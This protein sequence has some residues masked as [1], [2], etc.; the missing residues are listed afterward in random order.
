MAVGILPPATSSAANHKSLAEV[1]REVTA[2]NARVDAAVEAYNQSRI[3]LSA[4]ARRTAAAQHRL[5]LQA[6]VIDAQ[7]K[8]ISQVAVAAYRTGGADQFVSLVTTNNPESFLDRAASLNQISSHQSDALRNLQVAQLAYA[9]AQAVAR[10][11]LAEQRKVASQLKSHRDAIQSALAAEQSLLSSLQAAERARLAALQAAQLRAQRLA[12]QRA[13]TSYHGPASGQA[14]AAVRYAYAQ[15][16]KPYQWGASGPGSYDCSG[17]TMASWAAAGVSLP[18]SS[19]AQYGSG[20][21][22][23]QADIQPGDLVFFGSPIH[24]VGIY[25]G[26]GNMIHAPHTGTVVSIDPAF[27]GDYVGAVRP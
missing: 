8:A 26:G 4:A 10:Q 3:A 15:L 12:A 23:S 25:I 21:H 5:A 2:L 6:R 22:V 13:R 1:E 18:H 14:A 19:S 7:R 27:R 9:Q 11:Q 17:L 20:P 24:H 16:G